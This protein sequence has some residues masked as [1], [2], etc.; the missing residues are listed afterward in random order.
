[1]QEGA[2]ER[3]RHSSTVGA[4]CGAGHAQLWSGCPISVVEN[5]DLEMVDQS[6]ASWNPVISSLRNLEALRSAA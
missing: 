5:H 4:Q 2:G 3:L 1:M 6:S